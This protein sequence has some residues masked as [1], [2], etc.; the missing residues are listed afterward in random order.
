LAGP[1]LIDR[2]A[3]ETLNI[4]RNA[5]KTMSDT[6]L[7]TTQHNPEEK[8][9]H[10]NQLIL[11]EETLRVCVGVLGSAREQNQERL[12]EAIS[13][14]DGDLANPVCSALLARQKLLQNAHDEVTRALD[15]LLRAL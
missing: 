13:F 8:S 2:P 1:V 6:K 7:H 10:H 4:T 15:A 9:K 14:A 3:P 11:K 12:E 5:Q